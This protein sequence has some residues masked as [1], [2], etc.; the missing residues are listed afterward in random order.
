[1]SMSSADSRFFAYKIREGQE[2]N[3]ALFIDEVIHAYER[4]QNR[5]EEQEEVIKSKPKSLIVIPSMKGVILA[6]TKNPRILEYVLSG[7]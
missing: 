1:M 4:M 3:V 2:V 5:T 7:Q 6:E